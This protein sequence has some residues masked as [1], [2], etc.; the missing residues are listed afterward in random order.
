M[1]YYL[2]FQNMSMFIIFAL[3]KQER[4]T[5]GVERS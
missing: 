3:F 2:Y 1:K 5:V 4:N